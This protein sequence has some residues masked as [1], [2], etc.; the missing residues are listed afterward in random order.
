M[1]NVW[2]LQLLR[3]VESRGSI[4]AAAEAACVS[5]SAVSQQLT[6]LEREVGTP[7]LERHGRHVR[8]TDAGRLLVRHAH[9]ITGA[10][11]AAE[12]DLAQSLDR[13][14][15]TLRVAAF[16]TA[17]R[18]VMPSVIDAVTR[19]YQGLRI[20]LRDLESTESLD[21]LR[22]D[23]I[24]LAIID[25]YPDSVPV[26]AD[27][28]D[29]RHLFVD[30]FYVAS[31]ASRASRRA[32]SLAQLRDAY[33]IMDTES[34]PFFDAVM[35]MCRAS[36]FEPQIRANCKDFGVIIALVEG[37]LGVGMLPALALQNRAVRAVV[38]PTRPPLSRR[39]NAVVR[40][41][42]RRHP[43]I[44]AMLEEL[45]RFGSAYAAS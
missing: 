25:E 19:R 13:V 41:E 24:D 11:A 9:V 21:A 18:A 30:P 3:E 31:T 16:P 4:K 14:T 15:G 10:I 32:V 34:S 20:T 5:A 33:W 27:G 28:L 1:L 38:R 26:A 39:V 40:H 43:A 45:V 35:K 37:G 22:L 29:V 8:L 42:R 2:R 12:A 44:A 7:L 36:G 23:E 17:A 6:I